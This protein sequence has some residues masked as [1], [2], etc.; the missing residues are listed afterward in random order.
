MRETNPIT[1]GHNLEYG[2]RR[3]LK[4]ALRVSRNYPLLTKEIERLLN[5]PGLLLQGPFVEAIP[6]FHKEASLYQLC[7]G[8]APL[9][10]QDFAQLPDIELKR[11]LHR[12]QNQALQF[13]VG[14]KRNVIVATVAFGKTCR[15]MITGSET[16]SARAAR[17]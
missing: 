7:S 17:T 4:S 3:Y 12:H 5:Q 1:M 9:L 2:T 11:Q 6:D 16:P 15:Q 14:E 8:K 13:I 10:H